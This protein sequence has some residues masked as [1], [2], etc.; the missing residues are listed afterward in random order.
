VLTAV[1]SPTTV[2]WPLTALTIAIAEAIVIAIA[3][4]GQVRTPERELVHV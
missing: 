4:R 1:L 2:P 3:L